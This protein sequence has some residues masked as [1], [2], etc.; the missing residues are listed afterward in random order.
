M[1][2]KFLRLMQNGGDA[3]DPGPREARP[4]WYFFYGTLSDPQFLAK[5]AELNETP[6]LVKGKVRRKCIKYWG[7]Y[8]VLCWG[9]EIVCGVAWYAPSK[10]MVERLRAYETDAYAEHRLRMEL[11]NGEKV[12]GR[13]FMWNRDIE[14]LSEDPEEWR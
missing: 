9:E 1:Q 14:E 12:V 4:G 5:I 11:E 13:A 6:T 3:Y 7:P 8:R 2:R 10:E